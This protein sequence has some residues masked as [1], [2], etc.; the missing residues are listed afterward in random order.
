MG[1]DKWIGG[2]TQGSLIGGTGL[3]WGGGLPRHLVILH[4]YGLNQHRA[5]FFS[6]ECL[7]MSCKDCCVAHLL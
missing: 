7:K 3:Q 4:I 1:G 5:A 2:G 6:A